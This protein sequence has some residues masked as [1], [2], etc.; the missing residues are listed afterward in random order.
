MTNKNE[1]KEH[2]CL[3][4]GLEVNVRRSDVRGADSRIYVAL[5][6]SAALPDPAPH[7]RPPVPPPERVLK[8]LVQCD[9]G[10][11]G[12]YVVW[13]LE[14]THGGGMSYA[15]QKQPQTGVCM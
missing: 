12:V 9:E 14:T 10:M 4:K 5:G 13:R 6:W 7:A 8:W 3:F 11:G 1:R 2:G 15:V